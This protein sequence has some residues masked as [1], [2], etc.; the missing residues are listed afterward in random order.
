MLLAS[1]HW[2]GLRGDSISNVLVTSVSV[3]A[4]LATQSPGGYLYRPRPG[5]F[6]QWIALSNRKITIQRISIRE[7][8]WLSTG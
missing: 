5:R 3:G 1:T 6:K 7:T 8:N 4:M 2:L